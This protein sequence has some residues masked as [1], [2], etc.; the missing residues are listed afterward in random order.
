M[1]L[2]TTLKNRTIENMWRTAT[3]SA[4][5]LPQTATDDLFTISDGNV[6][7]VSIIGEWTTVANVTNPNEVSI[8]VVL[9][10]GATVVIAEPAQVQGTAIATG[11]VATGNIG[12]DLAVGDCV[13]A[14]STRGI[15]CGPGVIRVRANASET[16][17]LQWY[18]QWIPIDVGAG[19]VGA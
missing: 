2:P 13:M 10:S 3:K 5:N 17:A 7:I 14:G 9:T 4:A 19:V 11:F 6:L 15:I 18:C 12:D 8:E 1:P 16:G